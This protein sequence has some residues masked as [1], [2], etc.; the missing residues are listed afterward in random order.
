MDKLTNVLKVTLTIL[1][2]LISKLKDITKNLSYKFKYN[3]KKRNTI[4][5][6]YEN[7]IKEKKAEI[8]NLEKE[9]KSLQCIN[10]FKRNKLK[11]IKA[12][13][14]DKSKLIEDL[15]NLIIK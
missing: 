3:I 14:D 13:V 2:H 11:E 10:S 9:F 6:M 12:N 4:N 15:R 7:I 8:L 5:I 1:K